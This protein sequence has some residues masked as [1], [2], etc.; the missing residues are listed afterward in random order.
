M[1]RF[2]QH[3]SR[4][5]KNRSL[6]GAV[7]SYTGAMEQ[8]FITWIENQLA[9]ESA[10]PEVVLGVGDDGAILQ[11]RL[12][13][14]V[15][16]ADTIVE[17]VHF[18]LDIERLHRIGHKSLAINLSDIAAMGAEAES[19]LVSFALPRSFT[20]ENAQDLFAGIFATAKHFGVVVI[21]GDT[22]CHDGPLV[23]S[24]AATG[25]ISAEAQCPDGWRMD[26]AQVD[27]LLVVT[28]ALGGSIGGHHLDFHPR[29]DVAVAIQ[30]RVPINA[31][32]D[33]S[34]SLSIDLSHLIRKS[35]VG[36]VLQ[37]DQIP[38]SGAA[39]D[40]AIQSG[41]SALF[42]ALSDGEDFELLLSISRENYQRLEA[43]P[44]FDVPLTVI[45][46]CVGERIGEIEDAKTGNTIE[47][48]GYEHG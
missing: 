48:R 4:R 21:G 47:I 14:Q 9:S 2:R 20:L 28:G 42:H 32:T 44:S 13:K 31:A 33:I 16:V 29:L 22:T 19:A 7:F 24:I 36:A 35:G 38:L 3:S 23:I 12:S 17:N 1:I 10:A 46:R 15:L 26:G 8:T 25:R 45:G 30:H 18:E 40:L 11:G 6:R 34:D 43:D 5:L 39:H 41:K 37:C 27:D